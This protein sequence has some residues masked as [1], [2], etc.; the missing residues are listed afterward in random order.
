VTISGSHFT[1][2]SDVKFNGVSAGSGNFTVD[3]DLQ[4]T[5]TVPAGATTGPVTVVTGG[6]SSTTDDDFFVPGAGPLISGLSPKS[7]PVGTTVTIQGIHF[8]GT[9]YVRFNGVLASFTVNSDTKV[10]A[11]VPAGATSG[12]VKLKTP[13]GKAFSQGR[14]KVT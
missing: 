5:A 7:G 1:G 12:R 14:F 11:T 10:T 2:A 6:G 4:I 13:S 9:T 3:S 8:T